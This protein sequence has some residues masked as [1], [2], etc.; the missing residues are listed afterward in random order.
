MTTQAPRIITPQLLWRHK[1]CPAQLAIFAAEWPHGTEVTPAT[2]ARA[3]E[4]GLDFVWAA[5]LLS[6]LGLAEYQAKLAP[7]LAD[8]Q[9]KRVTIYAAYSAKTD[10][11]D[12][13]YQAKRKPI[14]ADYQA[15]M[16]KLFYEAWSS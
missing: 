13:E 7:I 10:P 14:D 3:L 4:L 12:A 15:S 8:Q 2:V 16:A 11:I 5:K 1:A 9:A 6:G